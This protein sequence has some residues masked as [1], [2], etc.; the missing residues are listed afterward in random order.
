[1]NT[2]ESCCFDKTH[3]SF[4]KI[5]NI[6]AGTFSWDMKRANTKARHW[7]FIDFWYISTFFFRK[8]LWDQFVNLRLTK[9]FTLWQVKIYAYFRFGSSFEKN[10]KKKIVQ[11]MHI[12]FFSCKGVKAN[13]WEKLSS[14]ERTFKNSATIFFK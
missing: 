12:I 14:G 9:Y 8:F 11:V 7:I 3:E 13:V 10:K 6:Y 4:L 2:F 1:M 5:T